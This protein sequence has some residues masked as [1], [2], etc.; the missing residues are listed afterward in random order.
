MSPHIGA[1]HANIIHTKEK[2]ETVAKNK[3]HR[4]FKTSIPHQNITT[5]TTEFKYYEKGIQKKYYFIPFLD[6]FNNEVLSF[7]ISKHPTYEAI[8][9]AL[10]QA[11]E[12]TSDC[13][14]RRPFHS[15]QG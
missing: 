9:T 13:P 2:S 10:T 12:A 4:C 11:L 1:N 14:Y 5:D 6:L 7:E 15:D 8:S 3:L